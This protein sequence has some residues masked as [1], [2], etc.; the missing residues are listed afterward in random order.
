M[1]RTLAF[2]VFVSS[3]GGAVAD[4]AAP[5][6]TPPSSVDQISAPRKAPVSVEQLPGDAHELSSAPEPLKA[7]PAPVDATR[8][9][10]AQALLAYDEVE[11][12]AFLF[13]DSDDPER[14]ALMRALGVNAGLSLEEAQAIARA[15]QLR[16]RLEGMLASGK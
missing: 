4:L 11:L 5:L 6:P 10:L 14:R 13:S 9:S 8:L 2:L 12:R 15:G 1:T 3:C 16:A 7:D